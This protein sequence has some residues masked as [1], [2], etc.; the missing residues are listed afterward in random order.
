MT[1]VFLAAGIGLTLAPGPDTFYTSGASL[2]Q[3]VMAGVASG[4][5]VHTFL[6]ALG[7]FVFL[8]TSPTTSTVILLADAAYLVHLG[9]RMLCPHQQGWNAGR[10]PPGRDD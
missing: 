4:L 3:G 10:L 8:A 5:V 2:E 7:V 9:W 6:A 1:F